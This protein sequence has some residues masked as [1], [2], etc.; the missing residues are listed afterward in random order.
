MFLITRGHLEIVAGVLFLGGAAYGGSTWIAEHDAR[1]KAEVTVQ[2]NEKASKDAETKSIALKNE[3]ADRDRASA[4][5]EKAMIAAIANLKTP[6]QIAPYVQKELAPGSLQPIIVS[7]P[8][9]TKDNPIPNATITIA[10]ADLPVLRDRLSKCDTDANALT[11]CKADAV[12]NAER[13]RLAGEKLSA[14]ENE[15]DAYKTELKG[16]T[17]WRRTKSAI[18]FILIGGAIG[19]AA[20]CGSGHCK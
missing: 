1:L 5:R 9:A 6:Q 13:S 10:Q 12:S 3:I 20:V 4:D 11:T 17:F 19:A 8:A 14:A 7:V 16:G 18:R 15:R 2:A